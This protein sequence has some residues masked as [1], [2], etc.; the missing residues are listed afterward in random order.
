[1]LMKTFLHLVRRRRAVYV[2]GSLLI[3]PA[4]RLW[5]QARNRGADAEV[6]EPVAPRAT[7]REAQIQQLCSPV[8]NR[9]SP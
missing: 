2:L 3:V 5:T 7:V 8:S 6:E 1:M 9:L 4:L